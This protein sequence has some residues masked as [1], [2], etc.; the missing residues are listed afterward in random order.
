MRSSKKHSRSAP[1]EKR[2]NIKTLSGTIALNARGTGFLAHPDYKTDI[3]ILP[4]NRN[5]AQHGDTVSIEVTHT[6]R[7]RTQGRV[8][9]VSE[10]ARNTF[11]G[12]VI[13]GD[14]GL[15]LKADARK[16]SDPI[17]I[18]SP[19][20]VKV[21]DKVAVRV[22][23]WKT[24]LGFPRGKVVHEIG[25]AGAHN[26][27]MEAIV[28]EG[29]F[30]IGF[31]KD[32][33]KEARE[34]RDQQESLMQEELKVRRD[35]RSIT[36]FTI[37]PVDAKDFD[38]ALSIETLANGDLEIGVHIADVS[39]YVREGGALD[40]EAL[41][42][43]F[44]VYL[45]DRTIPMLP[46]ILSNDL[47]SL[48]PNTDKLAYSA[49]FKIDSSGKVY[50]R[51]FGRTVIHSDKRFTYEEAQEIIERQSGKYHKELLALNALAKDMQRYRRKKGAIDFGDDEVR[52]VL[53][54]NGKPID[55]MRRVRKDAHKLVEEFMLL[56]N[57]EV[58]TYFYNLHQKKKT[59]DQ[60]LPL[61]YRVHDVPDAERVANL[62][63]FVR[64]LGFELPADT[65]NLSAKDINALLERVQG[66][67]R[68][69][70]IKTAA[71]RTMAKAVYTT[72]NTI[73]HFGLSFK[74]YTH[75]TSPIRR[76][77]DLVV[78][79]MLDMC[80]Q[81]QNFD[82]TLW[83][84]LEGIAERASG[85]EKKAVDAERASI[86]YKQV[87]YMSERIGEDFTG[88]VTGVTE[89]GVYVAEDNSKSEGMIKVRDLPDDYYNL[90]EKNYALVGE[91]TRRI[92]TLGD[93]LHIRVASANL[94]QRSIDYVLVEE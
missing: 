3:E 10:R 27:E 15:Y 43:S 45:V 92:F 22:E 91:R 4:E 30:E 75:F 16:M 73:G 77:P 71:L 32:V 17:L 82:T 25:K 88:T 66:D 33:E 21:H 93:S 65:K 70:L 28:I 14:T 34:I 85:Q 64:A 6:S 2:R 23:Q 49:V 56:A 80:Q 7:G 67:A 36:T 19:G 42:R 48:N 29:G 44:S 58:A 74:Y 24:N 68:E 94:E 1:R 35:M 18:D 31:P 54:D 55:V 72:K 59:K 90:D 78:H 53:D 8:L 26:T 89:W 86:K 81:R 84:K 76:Y 47:C 50:D 69:Q 87:E 40:R 39:F 38:D 63:V 41:K 52:F 11:V 13:K 12:V 5:S 37:D 83:K 20:N 46:E 79:R 9:K 60:G 62:A 57:R 51:W 61:I